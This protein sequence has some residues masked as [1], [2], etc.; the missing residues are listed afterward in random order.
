V[1]SSTR[2]VTE[3]FFTLETDV[4]ALRDVV[5][6]GFVV[7]NKRDNWDLYDAGGFR[8]WVSQKALLIGYVCRT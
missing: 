6:G 1:L 3:H 7:A 2:R 8:D 5:S 4:R